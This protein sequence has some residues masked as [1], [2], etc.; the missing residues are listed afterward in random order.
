[1][2]TP[3]PATPNL[4][5]EKNDLHGKS[6]IFPESPDLVKTSQPVPTPDFTDPNLTRVIKQSR[7]VTSLVSGITG[8][9]GLLGQAADVPGFYGTALYSIARIAKHYGYNPTDAEE[10]DFMLQVLLIG[11]LPTEASRIQ[12][13]AKVH[14]DSPTRLYATELGAIVASRG[15]VFSVFKL[16]SK[17]FATRFKFMVPVIG[18]AA[19]TAANMRFMESIL[20][21]AIRGYSRRSNLAKSVA[22]T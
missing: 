18:A 10:R 4:S 19:N 3:K 5:N 20:D 7:I 6:E 21:T 1:M 17:I 22:G 2:N 16:T 15:S 8:T 13:L 12:E 11:H 14:L 9:M